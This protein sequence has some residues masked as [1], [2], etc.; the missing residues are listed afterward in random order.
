MRKVIFILALTL[1]TGTVSFVKAQDVIK[2]KDGSE[3]RAKIV[4]NDNSI[5]KYKLYS[6]PSGPTYVVYKSEL[7]MIEYESGRK[8]LF[9]PSTGST[10]STESQTV[11]TP[12]VSTPPA[13][14]PVADTLPPGTWIPVTASPY[15]PL[16]NRYEWISQMKVKAPDIYQRYQKGS[17]LAGL[18]LGLMVGGTIA[19]IVGTVT[20]EKT[21]TTTAT[22]IEV[23]VKGVGGSVVAAG[24]ACIIIGTPFM[25]VGFS[26]KGKAKREYFRSRA[27]SQTHKSPLQSPHLEVRPNGLAFVF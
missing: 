1:F 6:N 24:T 3:I 8:E 17:R 23:Q 13:N 22:S 7:S 25:I 5:V 19:S 26:K 9:E 16:P 21:T 11:N 2:K 27:Y 18:G 20:G 4:E 15:Q 12:P 14:T 10:G